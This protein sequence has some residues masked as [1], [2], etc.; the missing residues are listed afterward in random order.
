M[1]KSALA[2]VAAAPLFATAALAGPYANVETNA[3]FFGNEYEGAVTEVHAGYE[4]GIGESASF[5]IQGGPAFVSVQD[6]D[7]ITEL[8]G[9]V[10][11]GID[12]AASTN[13]YGEIAAITSGEMDFD[14]DFALG[15]KL[16]VKHNF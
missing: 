6:E 10:G 5:Y 3:G 14:E 2:A 9:K 7:T 15:V 11:I 1:I 4:T 16:G 12:V 8:S 13:V